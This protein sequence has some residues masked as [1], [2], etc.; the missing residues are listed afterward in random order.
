MIHVAFV[1]H[2]NLCTK[3]IKQYIYSLTQAQSGR[4]KPRQ[5]GFLIQYPDLSSLQ[6]VAIK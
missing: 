4:A 5:Q 1:S 6:R 3:Y 2:I